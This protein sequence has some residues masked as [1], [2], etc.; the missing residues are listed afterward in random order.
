MKEENDTSM[1]TT[2]SSRCC[3]VDATRTNSDNESET[4]IT[5][6]RTPNTDNTSRQL[7]VRRRRSSRALPT[8]PNGKF[9][10]EERNDAY[11]NNNNNN[12]NN[13]GGVVG[14]FGS[15]AGSMS[16]NSTTSSGRM[17]HTVTLKLDFKS[18]PDEVTGSLVPHANVG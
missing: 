4:T 5:D 3:R 10:P 17:K 7:S 9:G 6:N 1:A 2:T 11:I 8:L 18:V 15:R 16:D 12:N 14:G 13:N